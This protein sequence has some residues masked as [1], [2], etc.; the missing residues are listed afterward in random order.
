MYKDYA[1]QVDDILAQQYGI[2][3]GTIGYKNANKEVMV[4]SLVILDL[5]EELKT[6][7]QLIPTEQPKTVEEKKPSTRK[8]TQK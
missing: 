5:M 1:K 3:K 7:K 8:T 2:G 6:I 4:L